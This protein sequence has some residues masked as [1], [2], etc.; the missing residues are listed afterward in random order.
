MSRRTPALLVLLMTAGLLSGG[1][2]ATA[3]S[4]S[5]VFSWGSNSFGQLG[6][7]SSTGTVRGA[8]GQVSL[9][10]VT[11]LS[12]GR[13]HVVA[14]KSDG[15][16]VSWGSDD[17]GQ[18]GNNTN[19]SN[20]STPVSVAG[21]TS[22]KDVD[23]G[24]YH[25]LALKTD[26]TVWGWGQNALGQLG[27]GNDT[28][29]VAVPVRWGSIQNAVGVYGGRD[30][31]YVLD[32]DGALWCSGG[33]GPEC[34]L[35]TRAE[36]RTPVAVPGLP[37]LLDVAGGRNHGVALAVDGTVWTWGAN[38]SGQL[39]RGD[40]AAHTAPQKVPG[41]TKVVDVGAGADHSMVVTEGG[42]VYV[43]G[44][45]SRGELGLGTQNNRPSPTLVSTL[46]GIVEVNAGR[47]HSFAI[48][49]DGRLWAWGW[50]EGRQV[51]TSGAAEILSP[52]QIPGLTDIVA[53][54][55]GQAYSVAL[56]APINTLLSDG[57]DAGL[58]GWTVKGRLR[59]DDLRGSP[60]GSAPSARSSGT[61]RKAGAWRALP[62]E[63]QSACVSTWVRP[64]SVGK[65]TTL[66]RLRG[67]SG[68][69]IAQLQL[70]PRGALRVRSDLDAVASGTGVALPFGEWRR[71]DLCTSHAP[72]A[73]DR[74]SVLVGGLPVGEWAWT[75][76]PAAQIQIGSLRRSTATVN[77]DDV[78]VTATP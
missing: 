55:G 72:G 13:E 44:A 54:E 20:S 29:P 11:D 33:N 59:L 9:A 23:D 8:P 66:L 19:L 39:G 25:S 14:L 67:V 18:L 32:A 24:H 70:G 17:F 63:L 4:G 10:D 46:S 22:V 62:G 64:V 21:L 36:I 49:G 5:S 30:M 47:S 28:S 16:V 40:F 37:D 76:A 43:W 48:G 3:A 74:V 34:G 77:Y 51:G 53:A 61:N 15:T 75:T 35:S 52:V 73:V 27:Q 71:I 41:L 60:V 2:G 69:G 12:G 56:T 7:G 42:Q 57:F 38:D 68:G 50:N 58:S 78:V 45:G 26:G 65:R 31:T 6:D 1:T